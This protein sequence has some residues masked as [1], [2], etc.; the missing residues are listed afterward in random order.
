MNSYNDMFNSAAPLNVANCTQHD[1]VCQY[2]YNI[3]MAS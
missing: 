1:D 2:K 3:N